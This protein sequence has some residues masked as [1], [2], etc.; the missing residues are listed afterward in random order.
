M[1]PTRTDDKL[2]DNLELW[3]ALMH[4][5]ICPPDYRPPLKRCLAC[6]PIPYVNAN[7]GLPPGVVHAA[8]SLLSW[9]LLYIIKCI[10]YAVLSCVPSTCNVYVYCYYKIHQ[11]FLKKVWLCQSE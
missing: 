6:S 9:C 4:A 7:R 5:L 8:V 10:L 3:K 2:A 1:A 11:R